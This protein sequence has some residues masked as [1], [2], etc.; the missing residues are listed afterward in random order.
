MK[1][2]RAATVMRGPYAGDQLSILRGVTQLA[3]G[4]S[5]RL[6]SRFVPSSTVEMV[7]ELCAS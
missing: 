3:R 7:L 1:R 6:C 5:L 2:G 4:G